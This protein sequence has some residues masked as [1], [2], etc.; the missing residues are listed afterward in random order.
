MLH[1]YGGSNMNNSLTAK[2][3][4]LNQFDVYAMDMRGQGESGGERGRFD[5]EQVLYDD[6]WA[7]IF[8]ACRRDNIDPKQTPIFLFGRSFG[9][10][11]AIKM[12]ATTI[13]QSMFR[14]VVLSVPFFGSYNRA[15]E[16]KKVLLG[17]ASFIKPHH[18]IA[19]G[20]EPMK[21]SPEFMQK[22][23]QFINQ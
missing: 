15:L 22:Y 1:G 3:L 17:I 8:E 19:L 5:S 14:G 2:N 21:G 4:A 6:Q 16:S 20:S 13:G 11:I 12:A 7:L 10:L 18:R 9:G 23:A